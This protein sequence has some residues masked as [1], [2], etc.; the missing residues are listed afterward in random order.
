[1]MSCLHSR[2]HTTCSAHFTVSTADCSLS[3]QNPQPCASYSRN[4]RAK[5]LAAPDQTHDNP[6]QNVS[7]LHLLWLIPNPSCYAGY[8]FTHLSQGSRVS[9]GSACWKRLWCI[10]LQE[11]ASFFNHLCLHL[12]QNEARAAELLACP[13]LITENN[14]VG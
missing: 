1:M 4:S 3:S 7:H 6:M 11:C 10:W 2:L 9:R 12:K 14:L 5:L 8:P 13:S